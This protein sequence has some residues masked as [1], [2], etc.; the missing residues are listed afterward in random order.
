MDHEANLVE[1]VNRMRGGY[2]SLCAMVDLLATHD[3]LEK[4]RFE[5]FARL[6]DLQQGFAESLVFFPGAEDYRVCFAG[7]SVFV[8]G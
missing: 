7:D 5:T 1:M 2:Q 6:N 3:M 8:G 4:N